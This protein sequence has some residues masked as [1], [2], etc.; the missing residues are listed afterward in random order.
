MLPPE[1]GFRMLVVGAQGCGKSAVVRR[2]CAKNFTDNY[3]P[4]IGPEL[5][6]VQ[7]A[8]KSARKGDPTIFLE[9]L[10]VLS[11]SLIT[12]L[13]LGDNCAGP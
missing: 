10:E 6:V 12:L 1:T 3:T 5:R 13:G 7:L 9:L 11:H 2:Y 8:A 4:T